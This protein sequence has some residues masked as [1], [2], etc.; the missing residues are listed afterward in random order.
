MT[1]ANYILSLFTKTLGE[2]GSLSRKTF[3]G[4]VWTSSASIFYKLSTLLRTVI[5]AR[6]LLPEDFGLFGIAVAALSAVHVFTESGISAFLIQRKTTDERHWNTGWVVGIIR[7]FV[8]F[9][10]LWTTSNLIANFYESPPLSPI[11]RV[12][13]VTVLLQGFN[14]I[15]IL[16]LQKKMEFKKKVFLDQLSELL[17]NISAIVLGIIYQSVWC[18]VL[19]KIISSL[20]FLI[21][22]YLVLSH[23]PRFFIDTS[24]LKEAFFFGRPLLIT[25]VL[26]YV[27]T[28]FDDILVGKLLGMSVLG[29]YTMAYTLANFPTIHVSRTIAQVVFPAYSQVQADLERLRRGFTSIFVFTA[30]ICIPLSV[31]MATLSHEIT[32]VI[33]GEKWLP[34]VPAFR[35]LC[36]LGLFRA[37][38]TIIGPLL[39]GYGKPVFL[40]NIKLIEFTVFAILIYPAVIYG[41]LIGASLLTSSVYALSLVLHLFYARK[42]LPSLVPLLAK[43]TSA[44]ICLSGLMCIVL[45]V[46]R[47]F[48]FPQSSLKGLVVL[49]IS[50][51]AIY[52][53]LVL[54]CLSKFPSKINSQVR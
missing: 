38:A 35:I 22:S 25:S 28:T 33:L 12:L 27:I 5:L 54:L 37:T 18:L 43:P 29:Y 49:L 8:L 47:V 34:M 11:L 7:G 21:L 46:E 30:A 17:G 24:I 36:F 23:R 45:F 14:N 40:R 16:Q 3:E 32:E 53:P 13:A 6:I 10:L 9:A 15:A 39:L 1:F 48:L 31:G 26:V 44:I 51:A 42:I 41:G 50:A 4:I 20:G 52:V 19:G 2:R